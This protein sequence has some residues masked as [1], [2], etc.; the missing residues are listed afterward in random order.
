MPRG[1]KKGSK[2]TPK[3]PTT[4]EPNTKDF[5][6]EVENPQK[7]CCSTET[8]TFCG[9]ENRFGLLVA[10]L[11]TL[12]HVKAMEPSP[13]GKMATKIEEEMTAILGCM[14]ALRE[15]YFPQ[16]HSDRIRKIEESVEK[17]KKSRNPAKAP[18]L[19]A[20]PRVSPLP[21]IEGDDE[22]DEPPCEPD[23]DDA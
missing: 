10:T 12:A 22:L 23:G 9:P 14:S 19:T 13:S 20:I 1:R 3:T 8:N 2:N 17:A 7:C 21:L 5:V 15:T 6:P 11:D 16:S 4:T 18:T